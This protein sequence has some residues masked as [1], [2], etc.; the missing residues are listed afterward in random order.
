[1]V[2]TA[3]G[4]LAFWY[5]QRQEA[6]IC[7]WRVGVGAEE[8]CLKIQQHTAFKQDVSCHF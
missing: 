4:A 5:V 6:V 1:M 8:G 2:G 7:L 3:A